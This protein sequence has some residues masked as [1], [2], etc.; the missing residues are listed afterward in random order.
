MI[1]AQYGKCQKLNVSENGKYGK[2]LKLKESENVK[3]GKCQKLKVPGN[4]KTGN[5]QKQSK[6]N[7]QKIKI[8]SY[9]LPCNEFW[10]C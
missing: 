6:W 3:T 7:C 9:R 5:C 8:Y 2:G 1:L 10:H 4:S